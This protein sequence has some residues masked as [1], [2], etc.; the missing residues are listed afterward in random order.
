ML[1]HSFG[2]GS[3][4]SIPPTGFNVEGAMFAHFGTCFRLPI[5]DRNTIS[6]NPISENS[7]A[8][9]CRTDF[10]K[11]LHGLVSTPQ[12]PQPDPGEDLQ[13][14]GRSHRLLRRER[15]SWKGWKPA[16]V[17]TGL[18]R[19]HAPLYPDSGAQA[20]E[21]ARRG[22]AGEMFAKGPCHESRLHRIA[23]TC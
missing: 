18:G 19:I 9:N 17:R 11:Q 23:G 13:P 15:V 20:G 5:R 6:A 22:S 4:G 21:P 14:P 16:P 12:V 8:C 2:N 10:I 7:R 1:S 3:F